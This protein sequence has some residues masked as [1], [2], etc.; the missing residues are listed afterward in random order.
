[1]APRRSPQAKGGRYL[2]LKHS[3][4]DTPG[5]H[6]PRSDGSVYPFPGTELP[7]SEPPLELLEA[8]PFRTTPP[9]IAEVFVMEGWFPGASPPA[10][11]G[12]LFCRTDPGIGRGAVSDAPI[13]AMRV[14]SDGLLPDPEGLFGDRDMGRF[15]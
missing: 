15:S 4:G 9:T 11:T 6:Q 14:W 3:H 13:E 12:I 5:G 10:T 2:R 8:R 1:M 7:V